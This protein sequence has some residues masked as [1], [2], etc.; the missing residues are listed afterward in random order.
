[1]SCVC[2]VLR[3]EVCVCVYVCKC[4]CINVCV[5]T[6]I[7]CMHAII[8]GVCVWHVCIY[9]RVHVY[10]MCMHTCMCVWHVRLYWEHEQQVWWCVLNW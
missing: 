8:H 6:C 7:V 9:V 2:C 4:A 1:M 5:H 10:C 3:D